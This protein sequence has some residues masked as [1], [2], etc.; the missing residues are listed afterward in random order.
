MPVILEIS[1]RKRGE[2]ISSI[3]ARIVGGK[4][5]QR[6]VLALFSLTWR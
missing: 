3:T 5:S 6:W 4:S 1:S 2:F